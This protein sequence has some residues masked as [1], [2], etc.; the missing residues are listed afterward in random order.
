MFPKNDPFPYWESPYSSRSASDFDWYELFNS[1]AKPTKDNTQEN[2]T[3]DDESV[4]ELTEQGRDVLGFYRVLQTIDAA[5]NMTVM[6]WMWVYSKMKIT[7]QDQKIL[8]QMFMTFTQDKIR[9]DMEG[10]PGEK[11][12]NALMDMLI[13]ELTKSVKKS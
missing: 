9:K 1:S 3:P 2:T 5:K 13:D 4:N 8:A 7:E 12:A 10:K 6:D 11:L